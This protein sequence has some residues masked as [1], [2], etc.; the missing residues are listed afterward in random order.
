MA[1]VNV[2][3][4]NLMAFDADVF[5]NWGCRP[6]YYGD[7]VQDIIQNKIKLKENI[8]LHPLDSI[9]EVIPMALNHKLK[10]RVIFTP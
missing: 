6:T 7:V 9:N 4:S 8:E 3:L 2:R 10:K 1:K 5:G